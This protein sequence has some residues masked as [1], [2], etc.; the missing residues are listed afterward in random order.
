MAELPAD[1]NDDHAGKITPVME[2]FMELK[3]ANPDCLLFYRMGDFYEMF[4]EDAEIAARI[5]GITL[6]KRGKHQGRDIPMAGV[7]IHVADDYLQRLI[8]SG[9]RVAVCEQM[10]DPAEARKRGSK[11]IV[12]RD[13][14]RLVTPGTLTE[15]NLLDARRSNWLVAVSRAKGSDGQSDQFAL[16]WVDIST[17]VF[18]L[19]EVDRDRLSLR[20]AA[21]DPREVLVSDAL[22]LEEDFRL[23][24]KEVT[25]NRHGAVVPLAKAFFDGATAPD[26]LSRYYGVQSLDSFGAF[27]RLELTAA[28]AILAYIEKTQ[29]A[30]RPMLDPPVQEAVAD[31]MVIDAATRSNLELMKTMGGERAG[32]LLHALDRTISGA[33][34]RLLSER[35]ASPSLNLATIR[36]RH[37][38][39]EIFVD[40]PSLRAHLREGL[41]AAPDM[42]RAL[43]RLSLNRGGPRDLKALATG[44]SVAGAIGGALVQGLEQPPQELSSIIADLGGAPFELS[45]ELDLA[46]GDDLPLLKRDGGFLRSG[47]D[48]RLDEERALRDQ[49]RQ[50]IANLQGTYVEQTGIRSLK[51]KY[52]NMLGYF[53]EVP[54][55]DATPMLSA[56]LNAAFIHRQTMAGALRFSTLELGDLEGRISS[57]GERALAIEL[58]TFDLL[59]GKVLAKAAVI[60]R[61]ADALAR[62]DVATSLAARA[63]EGGWVRPQMDETGAFVIAG[64]RHP[65]VEE[66][67]KEG[68]HTFVANDANLSPPPSANY[69]QIALITG[70]N[71]AGK[72]TYLRQNALIA[73][74]AQAGSFVPAT[75]A[76]IGL[77][78]RLFS[79]V[80]AAD[81]LARGRSTFMVE[82]I[83][84]AAILNQAG[85]RALVILDEIGRGT[86]TFDGL[87]IA[88]AAVE[89]L[90]DVN[91]CRALFATHYHELTALAERLP[92][93]VTRTVKVKEWK[94]DLVFLH[95]IVPGTA[96]RSY[97]VQVAKLAGIPKRAVDR[98][99]QVLE[100]LEKER[101]AV[102]PALID[103]LPLFSAPRRAPAKAPE[104]SPYEAVLALLEQTDP[105]D[106]TPRQALDA[107]FQL[108][109]AHKKAREAG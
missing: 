1:A 4:F 104:P 96:D 92:R 5:L 59:T 67:L 69:G 15:D 41:R 20:L 65:V 48:S 98:A 58:T 63:D 2:R 18:R 3:A 8:A 79:R 25:G 62:L 28:A 53:V 90:H 81:D 109:L 57:A 102:S 30:E 105:D 14:V 16:A 23:L 80:G 24:F 66:V 50:V 29:V 91:R 26:R 77:V 99:R 56:P 55:R 17:G 100:S 11:S 107:L 82:M 86:S 40:Q 70:P 84:T 85:P 7:P 73:V 54:Q 89:H 21:I 75:S 68:G 32:S 22:L 6:T 33:G 61:T 13:V 42:A 38:A 51:V 45:A 64:G 103:D 9:Q 44:I 76:H 10:E 88:W 46:L 94:G 47:Y 35:L 72:S 108:K 36:A 49:S 93:L 19:A 60:K 39:V 95:E 34:A 71:M 52:N 97:G 12:R 43:S 83:E 78:D 101:G 31:E 106:L 27:S 37:D 87:S 74:L